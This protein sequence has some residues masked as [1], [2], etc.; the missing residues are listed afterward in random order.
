[1]WFRAKAWAD[2]GSPECASRF[3]QF[4]NRKPAHARR[5]R[6][7]RCDR[8][9]HRG[10]F[11]VPPAHGPR[12]HAVEENGPRRR[13]G[14]RAHQ[15]A[16]AGARHARSHSDRVRSAGAVRSGEVGR[17]ARGPARAGTDNRDR[18]AA[19]ARPHRT[20]AALLRRGS[21]RRGRA[22]AARARFDLGDAELHGADLAVPGDPSS[23]A[24]AIAAAL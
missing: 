16:A 12:A 10:C 14:R 9:I 13:R 22:P 24:F 21:E 1:M 8:G 11:A 3:R 5:R 7:Q 18:E 17:P 23:A 2:C 15:F 4:R 19:D 6:R 20:H